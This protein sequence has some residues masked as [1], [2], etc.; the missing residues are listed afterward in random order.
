MSV[1]SS[2]VRQARVDTAFVRA[3]STRSEGELKNVGSS[4]MA[5]DAVHQASFL[6]D[7]F[8]VISA[9]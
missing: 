9:L 7:A 3:V 5:I 1:I 8:R 4:V 6:L 2:D